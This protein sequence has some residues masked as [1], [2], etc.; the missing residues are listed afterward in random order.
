M[1]PQTLASLHARAFAWRERG[2]SAAEFEALLANPHTILVG[3]DRAFLVGRSIAEEA[4]V[5]TL[6]TDPDQRRKG[7][8]R[9]C[10]DAFETTACARG[11]VTS[12]LEVAA[13]NG[14]AITLY[15]KAGYQQISCRAGYYRRSD[16]PSIDALIL[17]KSLV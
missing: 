14:P 13:D 5:L 11:A 16:S 8:G 6:A 9:A 3:D 17:K 15:L 10:L 4:E 1:T 12:L 2:W 7:L